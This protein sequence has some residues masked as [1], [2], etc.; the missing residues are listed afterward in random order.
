MLQ[1]GFQ[2]L[3]YLFGTVTRS[4]LRSAKRKQ[5]IEVPKRF[6]QRRHQGHGPVPATSTIRHVPT[7]VLLGSKSTFRKGAGVALLLRDHPKTGIRR[8]ENPAFRPKAQRSL[9]ST[10]RPPPGK[11]GG[12]ARLCVV[13]H[14]HIG[15]RACT[16]AARSW[17]HRRKNHSKVQYVKT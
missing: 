4:A 2:I 3:C 12:S 5:R 11:C 13:L 6:K 7:Q 14:V 16:S 1:N 15:T 17:D 8:F 9:A 10:G